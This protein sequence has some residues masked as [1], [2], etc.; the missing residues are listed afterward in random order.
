MLKVSGIISMNGKTYESGA[1][2]DGIFDSQTEAKFIASGALVLYDRNG[3]RVE[4]SNS[5]NLDNTAKM[6]KDGGY[7]LNQRDETGRSINDPEY[8]YYQK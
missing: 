1:V 2:V 8:T 4:T 3:L 5:R 6:N 7:T